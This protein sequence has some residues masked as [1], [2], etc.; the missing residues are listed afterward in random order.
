MLTRTITEDAE[1]RHLQVHHADEVF[2][3]VSQNRE[4]LREWLPWVA[5][6]TGPE[7]TASFIVKSLR[8]FAEGSG[9]VLG[10]WCQGEFAGTVGCH[11]FD[12]ANKRVEIGYWLAERWQGKGIVTAACK[13]LVDHLF[14]ELHMHRVEIR[15]APDN[16]KSR[17]IA[18]RLGFAEEG[19]AREAQLRNGCWYDLVMYSMLRDEW[20]ARSN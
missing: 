10:I 16:Y 8:E 20:M 2:G 7:D 13:A 19:V 17:A 5:F 9:L 6:T 15:A 11:P 14:E 4:Y 18:I 12:L 3:V 1:L